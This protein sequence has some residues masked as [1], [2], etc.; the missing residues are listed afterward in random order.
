MPTTIT[1]QKAPVTDVPD[2]QSACEVLFDKVNQLL[3]LET[4]QAQHE[5]DRCK[6]YQSCKKKKIRQRM[7]EVPQRVANSM[8]SVNETIG[9]IYSPIASAI[10]TLM[11]QRRLG[12]R[13]FSTQLDATKAKIEA[14]L[15][16]K[17]WDSA[18]AR[19]YKAALPTQLKALTEL[20]SMSES[21]AVACEQ[22]ALMNSA[23]FELICQAAALVNRELGNAAKLPE[24][25]GWMNNL[26]RWDTRCFELSDKGAAM[27]K[28]LA[29][30]MTKLSTPQADWGQT[31]QVL[32]GSLREVVTTGGNLGANGQ[33]PESVAKVTPEAATVSLQDLQK[34]LN[35]IVNTDIFADSKNSKGS[36]SKG[37]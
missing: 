7:R 15:Q 18:G 2:I 5:L 11:E 31:A 6:W 23:V 34:K 22:V 19:Q 26:E 12:W 32:D 9:T 27:T 30:W 25:P 37:Q 36:D 8:R 10:T 14:Q 20:S 17:D 33:W 3:E 1:G 16:M 28:A 35:V 29:D 13:E 21:S 4:K 24:P